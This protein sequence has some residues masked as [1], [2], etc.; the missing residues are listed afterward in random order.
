MSHIDEKD[1]RAFRS[2]ANAIEALV[3]SPIELLTQHAPS[4]Q[5]MP[6]CGSPTGAVVTGIVTKYA[7]TCEACLA[8]FNA[9]QTRGRRGR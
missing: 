2:D 4:R 5:R 3:D 1:D 8:K 6:L 9:R 7:I